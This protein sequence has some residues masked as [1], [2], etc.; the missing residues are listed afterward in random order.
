MTA[1]T[2]LDSVRSTYDVVADSYAS[3]LPDAG[4]EAP[5]DRGMIEAF[6]SHVTEGPAR[7]VV[8]AGCGTGRMT[9]LLA[10]LGVAVS[11]I[12]LSAGMIAVA[13]RTSPGLTF[14]V[15]EL[16]ELPY[17]DTQLG[18]VFAWY[19]IIHTPPEDLPRIF[20]EFFRVLAPGGYA[21]LG[22]QV[23]EGRRHL[24][25]A[26]GHD[27]SLETHLFTP[28]LTAGHLTGAGFTV[29]AQMTRQGRAHEKT[30]QAVLLARRPAT[31]V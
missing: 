22:F 7:P 5:A 20:A 14:E 4:F 21:L 1:V 18:G 19:S 2:R 3:L 10:S 12:D 17:A 11:G 16:S 15:A 30:P 9:G 29:T 28:E 13:R 6:A 8:D 25:R 24:S 31:A 26:Y 27:V 23:G